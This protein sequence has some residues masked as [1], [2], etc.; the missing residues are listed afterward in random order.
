MCSPND[1]PSD[2]ERAFLG[3]TRAERSAWSNEV[4]H[5][6][7]QRR[8]SPERYALWCKAVEEARRDEAA[9]QR[10]RFF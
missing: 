4:L 5:A 6:W 8:C 7:M 2:A 10:N 3:M 1:P 9:Q